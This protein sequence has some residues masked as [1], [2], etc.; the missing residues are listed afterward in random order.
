[1]AHGTLRA[2]GCDCENLAN[3][4]QRFFKRNDS[5]R[6]NAI[7]VGDEND[8]GT[9]DGKVVLKGQASG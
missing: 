3:R 1:M 8:H 6:L 4:T 9:Y 2:I 7:I 5:C